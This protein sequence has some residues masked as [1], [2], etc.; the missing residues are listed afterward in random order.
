MNVCGHFYTAF[1]IGLGSLGNHWC[2]ALE[3]RQK[4]PDPHMGRKKE[5]KIM[6]RYWRACS[7]RSCLSSK[8]GRRLVGSYGS[9]TGTDKVCVGG[10]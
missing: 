9:T 4:L 2:D 8:K 10:G 7:S 1:G 3:G 6:F 5:R